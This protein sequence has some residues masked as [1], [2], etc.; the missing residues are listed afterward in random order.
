[1]KR[2]HRRVAWLVDATAG[3]DYSHSP[4][5]A[6]TTCSGVMVHLQLSRV[7]GS[8]RYW[9][10]GGAGGGSIQLLHSLHPCA[11][12]PLVHCLYDG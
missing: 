9:R 6:R 12:L 3:M 1:M 11:A 5:E 8:P 4:W 7:L 2:S 10:I